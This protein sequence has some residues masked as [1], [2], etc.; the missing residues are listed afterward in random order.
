MVI[1]AKIFSSL[2]L[3]LFLGQV[4]DASLFP[5]THFFN[6]KV[7]APVCEN[8]HHADEPENN[9]SQPEPCHAQEQLIVLMSATVVATA[10]YSIG[11]V[12]V[13]Y[14]HEGTFVDPQEAFIQR[15]ET[16]CNNFRGPPALAFAI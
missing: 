1:K 9:E 5:H 11:A 6:G 4:F 8:C 2:L 12:I 16:C 10:Q 7:I 14:H 13:P 3:L 15:F